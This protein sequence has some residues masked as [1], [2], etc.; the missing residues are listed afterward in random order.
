MTF[1]DNGGDILRQRRYFSPK[2]V[3][4]SPSEAAKVLICGAPSCQFY[5]NFYSPI[6]SM[7]T[8]GSSPYEDGE[9]LSENKIIFL[10]FYK[11]LKETGQNFEG[12]SGTGS[13]SVSSE[14][15]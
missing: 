5:F 1:K 6:R 12:C 10:N 15:R 14:K 9:G 8:M 4:A 11:S 13:D 2:A 7:T 3:M